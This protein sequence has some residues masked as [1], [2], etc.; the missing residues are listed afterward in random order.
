MSHRRMLFV[1]FG[2]LLGLTLSGLD[3]SIVATAAP[4]ILAE[5]GSVRLLPWLT[6]SYLLAQVTTMGLFGKVGDVFGR[7]R[8]FTIAVSTFIFASVLCGAAQSMEMLIAFRVLQGFG[9][10]GITALGMALVSDVVPAEKLGRYLGYTGIVFAITSILGPTAGGFFTDTVSWR[11]A[12]FVNIPSGLL[13]LFTLFFAPKSVFD[14]KQKIDFL[15]AALLGVTAASTLLAIGGTGGPVVWLSFRTLGLLGLAVASGLAFGFRQTRAPVPLMPLRI[16]SQRASFL[17][18]MANLTTGM[19]F[20]ASIVYPPLF[21]QAVVGMDATQA[22]LLLG[23]FA[24]TSAFTTLMAGQLTDRFGGYKVL[25]FIGSLLCVS[26]FV[27]LSSITAS[28]SALFIVLFAMVGGAGIGFVMQTL[29][30]VVHRFTNPQDVGSATSAVMLARVLGNAMG[31]A[32]VGSV[33]TNALLSTV[34]KDLPGLPASEL[35]GSPAKIA[36]L[37]APA[38]VIVKD[39]F[40]SS[41]ATGFRAVIPFMLVGVVLIAMLP[42]KKI[43][44]RVSMSVEE[45]PLAD[46]FAHG[47]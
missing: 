9:A 28:T 25:P 15:G 40:A 36:E 45:V 27:L 47:G 38:Q 17:A 13:C 35:Q 20:G 32:V 5:L 2:V 24:F 8:M 18:L 16:F 19:A 26:S 43:R 12:F 33:F 1:F 46:A 41:L 42:A 31:V 37:S 21:F 39:A 23:P 34:S 10:G 4:S 11:F 7:R 30:F 14:R 6:T 3:G 22:G 29:L 44:E